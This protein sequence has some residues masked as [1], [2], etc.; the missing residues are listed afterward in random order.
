[1]KVDVSSS[2]TLLNLPHAIYSPVRSRSIQTKKLQQTEL[3]TNYIG[4]PRYF[5]DTEEPLAHS[6]ALGSM[7]QNASCC[8]EEELQVPKD[9]L[10][11][12]TKV[13]AQRTT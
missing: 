8:Q 7:G 2:S 11:T 12:S 13:G 3:E 1:M 6:G 5:L 4:R 10:G 9:G